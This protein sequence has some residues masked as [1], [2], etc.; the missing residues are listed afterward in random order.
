MEM[1]NYGRGQDFPC[2]HDNNNFAWRFRKD[3]MK[4]LD[5]KVAKAT[6]KDFFHLSQRQGDVGNIFRDSLTQDQKPFNLVY[7]VTLLG[8]VVV[9]HSATPPQLQ[10]P[11]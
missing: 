2:Y 4:C 9:R 8:F 1:S 7:R 6:D 11:M 3:G 10:P 5:E